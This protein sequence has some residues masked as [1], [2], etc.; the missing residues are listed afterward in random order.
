[1]PLLGKRKLFYGYWILAVAFWGV[2]IFSGCGTGTFSLF[3]KPLQSEFGWG[4]GDIMVAFTLFFLFIGVVSPFAGKLVDR[5]GAR[6]V[7]S[8]GA[9]VGGLGFVS[10]N[11]MHD[12]W[13]FY[14]GY[15]IIGLG[16]AAT[17]HIPASALVSNWFRK[18]R[19]TAIGI[20][21]TGIGV[22]VLALAPLIGYYLIPHF[23]WRVSY[24]TLAIF[25]WTLIPLALFVVRTKPA[26][27]GLYPDGVQDPTDTLAAQVPYTEPKG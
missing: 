26:D 23:G 6:Y 25:M 14:G 1:M 13:H 15:A 19:G 20:M 18:W 11:L 5:Y 9:F 21:S 16:M 7:I 2:F 10:L 27:M 8:L 17:G 12:L 4:R 24:L 22:G 3:V